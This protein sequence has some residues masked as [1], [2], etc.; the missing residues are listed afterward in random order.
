MSPVYRQSD[1]GFAQLFEDHSDEGIAILTAQPSKVA[2]GLIFILACL[3]VSALVWS[4]FGQA[5]VVVTAQGVVETEGARF[6]VHTPAKGQLVDIYAAEDM[7]VSE[8]DVLFRI[9]SPQ[10]VQIALQSQEAELGL[11]EAKSQVEHWPAQKVYLQRILEATETKIADDTRDLERI[12]AEAIANLTEQQRIKL[13][14]A[15]AKLEKA[16]TEL[17]YAEDVRATYG[18]LFDSE[19]GGG[20]SQQQVDEKRKDVQEKQLDME[21]ARAEISEFESK[22]S[23]E[24]SKKQKEI[25]EKR[26]KLAATI[27]QY[28][29]QQVT[30]EK[31]EQKIRGALRQAQTRV[32]TRVSFADIDGDNL[33]SVRAPASGVVATVSHTR[34]GSMIEDKDPVV[35]IVP[36]DARKILQV[37]IAEQ[38]RAFLQAG[39]TVKIKVNAFPYQRYGYLTGTLEHISPTAKF[40]PQTKRLV[41]SARVGLEENFFEIDSEIF[42][43]RYGMA[44]AAEITVRK[45]RIIDI[46]LDPLR[47][48]VG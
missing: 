7:A 40:N 42:E 18:R 35:T 16:Q 22:M 2:R 17:T 1:R 44:A 15:Q 23:E 9:D 14:K 21:L 10:A 39:M 48:T 41:Y 43:V 24:F 47:K 31:E 26:L 45:R 27:S 8:G 25:E 6:Q 32:R 46:A 4:F 28:E 13:Q 33:L 19:G 3:L 20:I 36:N 34:A 29:Q 38:D 11:L 12:E 5:D 30:I 37:E